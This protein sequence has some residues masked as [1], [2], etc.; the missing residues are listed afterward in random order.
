MP[1]ACL[2]SPHSYLTQAEVLL[3]DKYPQLMSYK[4]LEK[5]GHFAALQV[6]QVVSKDIISFFHKIEVT[7]LIDLYQRKIG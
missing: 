7:G 3:T 1:T 5:G 6:P 4:T 2:V